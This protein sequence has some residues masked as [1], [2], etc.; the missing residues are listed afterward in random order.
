MIFYLSVPLIISLLPTFVAFLKGEGPWKLAALVMSIVSFLVFST[1]TMVAAN[2][3]GILSVDA[4][5][6]FIATWSLSWL[7][8]KLAC[9]ERAEERAADKAWEA[10]SAAQRKDFKPDVSNNH[11]DL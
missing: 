9:D 5:A 1:W 8:T 7:F 3:G 10:A 2:F 11:K 4:W 6:P